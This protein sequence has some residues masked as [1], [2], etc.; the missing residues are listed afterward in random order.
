MC[1]KG[2]CRPRGTAVCGMVDV[3][4]LC[5]VLWHPLR[6]PL[7]AGLV[8]WCTQCG[9][10]KSLRFFGKVVTYVGKV[11]TYFGKYLRVLLSE[12]RGRFR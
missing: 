3:R 5:Q 4:V 6:V 10:N 12:H 1:F 9:F 11:V 8:L 2:G 7:L